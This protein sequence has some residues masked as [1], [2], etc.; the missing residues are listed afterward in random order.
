MVEREAM[1]ESEVVLEIKVNKELTSDHEVLDS[2]YPI[3][4]LKNYGLNCNSTKLGR[5]INFLILKLVLMS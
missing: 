5:Y 4:A 1:L 2:Q 3:L